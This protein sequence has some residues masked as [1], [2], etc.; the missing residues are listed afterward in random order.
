MA[1]DFQLNFATGD[2]SAG[3]ARSKRS[4]GG[5][6]TDRAKEKKQAKI[7]QRKATRPAGAQGQASQARQGGAG[8]GA[9][10]KRPREDDG[11]GQGGAPAKRAPGGQAGGQGGGRPRH[12]QSE[13]GPGGK[14]QFI[15]SLFTAEG[16]PAAS[17]SSADQAPIIPAQPSNAPLTSAPAAAEEEENE[18]MA[19]REAKE[20][21]K[22]EGPDPAPALSELGLMRPVVQ[23]LA[24]KLGITGPTACQA[25]AIPRLVPSSS[26]TSS[27]GKKGKGKKPSPSDAALSFAHDAIL[28]AQTGSGKT[29]TFLLP[30]L[31]DLLTLDPSLLSPPSSGPSSS[32]APSTSSGTAG[33]DIG[34]LSLILAP[35]RELASQIHTVLSS[36]LSA[37]PSSPH[38]TISPRALTA[39]LL[40]GGANRTHEK[41]RLRKG[42][43]IVVATPGRLLDHLKTTEAFRLAG[44]AVRPPGGKGGQG[45]PRGKAANS[46]PL[47]VR[48]GG[49]TGGLTGRAAEEAKKLGLRWLIVDEC[50]RLMDLGF[51]EQMRGI[52]EELKKREVASGGPSST[53]SSPI[54]RR[55]ILCSATASEGVDR[56]AALSAGS[57]PASTDSEEPPTTPS[58]PILGASASASIREPVRRD[59]TALGATK[60]H[61]P[62]DGD[63]EAE[64]AA[65]EEEEQDEEAKALALPTGFT[66]PSQLQHH[67]LVVPPK[68]RF[69]ALVALL[70]KL[71]RSQGAS[72][73]GK[74]GKILVFMSCTE[75]VEFWWK[76]LGGIEMGRGGGKA[77]EEGG[78]PEK[79]KQETI[80]E[81]LEKAEAKERGEDPDAAS[82]AVA[83][84]AKKKGEKE[85]LVS[86]HPLLPATPIYRLHGN[87]PLSTRL[88]SLAA[89]SGSYK[90]EEGKKKGET[91]EQGVLLCTSVAARGLDVRGV[92]SV[93]Q[94]DAPTEGGVTE[95]VHRVGRTARAGAQGSA[96]SFLLPTETEYTKLL[97]DGINVASTAGAKRVRLRETSVEEVLRQ[98]YGGGEGREYET[99]AT[100]VQMGFERW[101]N[102]S[103]ENAA[104][105]R[106]AFQAHVRAYATHPSAEKYIFNTKAL[107]LGH[108]AKSFGMRE[109]PGHAGQAPS[110][111]K[112]AKRQKTSHVSGGGG[113]GGM[114]SKDGGEGE[115]EGGF[116][117]GRRRKTVDAE[118]R[119]KKLMRGLSGNQGSEFQIAGT[120][121]IKGAVRR[122]DEEESG[123]SSDSSSSS[124]DEPVRYVAAPSHH[125]YL[126]VFLLVLALCAVGFFVWVL[127]RPSSSSS[128][129]SSDSLP[130]FQDDCLTAHNDFRAT[131]NAS[132]LSWNDTLADAA[133]RWAKN[134]V[135][136]H[137]E[138]SLLSGSYGENLFASASDAYQSNDT[139]PMNA[140]AGVWAWNN[141]ESMYDYIKPTGFTEETGHFTQTV[142]KGTT[143]VGCFFQMCN[144]IFSSG[145]Y[146][147]YLVCEYWPPGNIVTDDLEYFKE[148]VQSPS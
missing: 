43:P 123:S 72:G 111:K 50:D 46:V 119:M 143:A 92:G 118:Q 34:T 12:L 88:A 134:C 24:G 7:D 3:P 127:K 1:D 124:E 49:G 148:N 79:R 83:E 26:S 41:R 128:D 45:P 76:A 95:Y 5:R 99:R 27:K 139:S 54:R 86:L 121:E 42:C 66:P 106:R 113:G 15:S 120:D 53:S 60:R 73:G 35:T 37:L 129:A 23:A 70:R 145:Q 77:G 82:K 107:H 36:L 140:T 10:Q 114:F 100:D 32:S 21:K 135:W 126:V 133:E 91:T 48:G 146:G 110:G 61:A 84:A 80:E 104:D 52:L 101:V 71:L 137:S 109:A 18:E 102:G 93:V 115:K 108:L 30:M 87:L 144:G 51:E 33:R 89:F 9:G 22:D 147:V 2:D 138:G 29:L 44:E 142:W 85:M 69:V 28:R 14:K 117:T 65:G 19:D 116:E 98:G 97:E 67:Y 103:E 38:F 13:A 56:L 62:N 11:A 20:K 81:Q 47:G 94:V 63:E 105:A 96:Y 25:G 57:D 112:D 141:E 64:P 8:G 68:L 16:L 130:S 17:S 131:H 132:A 40:V 122:R 74:G 58:W 6:W 31:Q 78:K 90:I 55:T 125:S 136:K 39:G 75:A 59:L 4:K